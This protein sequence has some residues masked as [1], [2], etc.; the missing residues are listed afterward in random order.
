MNCEQLQCDLPDIME[1]ARTREQEDHLRSC[2][3]C[4]D[5][6]SDLELISQE[7]RLLRASDEPNPRVWNSIEIALRQEGLI[8]EPPAQPT[9]T[10]PL[11]SGPRRWNPLWLLPIPAALLIA[12]GIMRYEQK[13]AGPEAV[14]AHSAA[15][16]VVASHHVPSTHPASHWQ[17]KEAAP[18]DDDQLLEA[19]SSQAPTL[20]ASYE[21]DLQNVNSY[22]RDAE[23]SAQTNPNDEEAQRYLMNAYD[24]KAMMY[25]MALDHSLP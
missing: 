11:L 18:A 3:A 22:I 10:F 16:A 12:F 15:P 2:Q 25:E 4:S 20:R 13:P 8:H 5:L 24:Q 21:A 17:V 6:L 19:V 7:A 9:L 1:G 23:E 14:A